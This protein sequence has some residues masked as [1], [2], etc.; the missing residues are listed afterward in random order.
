[1]GVGVGAGA[2]CGAGAGFGAGV[3]AGASENMPVKVPGAYKPIKRFASALSPIL[4]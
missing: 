2:G 4:L 1:M 3:A